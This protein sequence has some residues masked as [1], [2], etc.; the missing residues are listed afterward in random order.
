MDPDRKA[1]LKEEYR[2]RHVMVLDYIEKKTGRRPVDD[3]AFFPGAKNVWAHWGFPAWW[4]DCILI[5][6]GWM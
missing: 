6:K 3:P 4:V 2:L 5:A 1:A